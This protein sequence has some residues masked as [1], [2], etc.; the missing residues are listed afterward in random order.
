MSLAA[1][2]LVFILL[3]VEF[4]PAL[5]GWYSGFTTAY[6]IGVNLLIGVVIVVGYGLR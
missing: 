4:V 1:A 2:F 6:L 3:A 5:A